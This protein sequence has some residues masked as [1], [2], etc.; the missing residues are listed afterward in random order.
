MRKKGPKA[1]AL[2]KNKRNLFLTILFI[3][4]V[5]YLLDC[6]SGQGQGEHSV[7][8]R[9]AS[10]T[11]EGLQL[12]ATDPPPADRHLHAEHYP[13]SNERRLDLFKSRVVDLGGGYM[14]VGTDQNLTLIAWAKS[15]FAYL[16]DFDP[17]TVSINR[18]H[19]H[20]IEI[21]PT[22]SEFETLW[23]PKR[24]DAV[25]PIIEKRFSNDPE[26]QVILKSYQI[27]LRKGAVPQRLGD[28]HKISKIYPEFT[29]FH[30]DP[31]DY[32]Y[33]RNMILEGKIIAIDGNLLG[34]KT[35]NSISEKAKELEV[36]IRILYTSNAEEYFRY[37]EV[38]RKNFLNLYSDPKS[39]VV[40]TVTK[41]AKVYGF[42]DGEMFPREFP[43]HY[44]IQALENLKQWLSKP[45]ILYTTILLRNRKPIVKGFS[46]IEALPGETNKAPIAKDS[47]ATAPKR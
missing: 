22:Y 20:F 30:N 32:E 18:L 14:G 43:F 46:V 35:I 44:N 21:S 16:F 25:L 11:R 33:L 15:E 29:S 23:D 42:P 37:P 12:L 1:V 10:L 7:F 19:L 38:M 31:K 9:K 4:S 3:C 36:P 39:I 41:G 45:D 27:A 13:S 34:D 28:L 17:V 2:Y 47:N 5:F 40:R 6:S 8:G 24:K 26:Y